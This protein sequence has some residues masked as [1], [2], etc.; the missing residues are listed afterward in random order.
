MKA[1]RNRYIVAAID[2]GRPGSEV[3]TELGI[4]RERVRQIY[5]RETGHR[6]PE[7]GTP[8]S[9]CGSRVF[10]GNDGFLAHR[11]GRA[12]QAV[13]QSRREDRRARTVER[14]FESLRVGDCWE[15]KPS[16]IGYAIAP[17]A[18]SGRHV[19]GHR[20]VWELLVGPIP[21]GMHIDHLCRNRAC[22]NPAHLEVVTAAVN[23]R[24]SP[25]AVAAINARKTHCS[26]GH[27]LDDAYTDGRGRRCR[28]CTRM[29]W[30]RANQA[31]SRRAVTS[32]TQQQEAA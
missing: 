15:G 29:A 4:S 3:A 1:D 17:R 12:H 5:T 32:G 16:T 20:F 21:S 11:Q 24:R 31:R 13:V 8:C 28:P 27:S 19:Y 23:V 2:S 18:E 26:R 30:T 7:R 6:I 9:R 10:G 25:V 22:V 14:W